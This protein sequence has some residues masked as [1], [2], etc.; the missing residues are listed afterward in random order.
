MDRTVPSSGNEEINLYLRTYYSLLRSTREVKLKSLIEAHKRTRSALH[1]KA[2]E[3]EV[4]MA[5]FIYAIL[6]VPECLSEINLVIMGQSSRVFAEHGFPQIETWQQV[7]APGRRRRCFFDGKTTLACYIASRSD[8]DDLVPTLVAYQIERRKLH[9]LLAKP[10]VKTLLNKLPIDQEPTPEDIAHL[11]DLTG[12]PTEDLEKLSHIWRDKTIAKFL[13]IADHQQELSIRSLAGSLSDYKRAI[14]RWWRN[15]EACTPKDIRFDERPVYFVSSNTH[16]LTN[17][18][19][20]FALQI[21]STLEAYLLDNG[22]DEL[23][24]EYQDIV[25]RNIPSSL[26]NFLYY[27]LKKYE[28]IHPD[29]RKDRMAYEKS[30]GITRIQSEHAFDIE[31]QIVNL[32]QAQCGGDGCAFAYSGH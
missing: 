10:V 16:S 17:M 13:D 28:A 12:I 15:V 11:A 18:L 21:E 20:G 24:Q 22:S 8:I 19:S 23:R 30:M 4:D 9:Y 29:V 32:N 2:D 14:R 3:Q 27:V 1:V 31:V 6:R 25:N 5:A 7:S 26:E